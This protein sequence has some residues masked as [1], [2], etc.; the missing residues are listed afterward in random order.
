MAAASLRDAFLKDGFVPVRNALDRQTVETAGVLDMEHGNPRPGSTRLYRD[1][2][3]HVDDLAAARSL[4]SDKD[5]FFYQDISNPASY[6]IYEPLI[7]SSSHRR[8]TAGSKP[9]RSRMSTIVRT[10]S[11]SF[12]T[13]VIRAT[14]SSSTWAVC[15]A[16]GARGPA[17]RA[18]PWH[19]GSSRSGRGQGDVAS[20]LPQQ[21][22]SSGRDRHAVHRGDERRR[23]R[24]GF[25]G[26]AS[27]GQVACN[28]AHRHTAWGPLR[29]L[30]SKR[31]KTRS[32]ARATRPS[33]IGRRPWSSIS[34][35]K[36]PSRTMCRH[37]GPSH[38]SIN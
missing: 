34:R 16:A 11:R 13:P 17:N 19:S 8:S 14:W 37:D 30:N 23:A 20:P 25:A 33:W 4:P 29:F 36:A 12:P 7:T 32:C 10:N 2:M 38:R 6:P 22:R 18:A 26:P 35:R 15:T 3:V 1:S 27:R 24:R 9:L 5:G 21:G 31:R 28:A